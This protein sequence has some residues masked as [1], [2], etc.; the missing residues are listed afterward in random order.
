MNIRITYSEC[1]H[2][3]IIEITFD[4]ENDEQNFIRQLL[5]KLENEYTTSIYIRDLDVDIMKYKEFFS[6]DYI[7]QDEDATSPA[8][9]ATNINKETLYNVVGNWGFYSYKA[10]I[11]ITNGCLKTEEIVVKKGE[12]MTENTLLVMG[13]VL[14]YTLEVRIKD[15][16]YDKICHVWNETLM[17]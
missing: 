17:K 11:I 7:I 14:D 9:V 15:Y 16:L 6:C 4:N 10:F 8:I 1:E 5:G 13:Q 2:D 12:L 3:K